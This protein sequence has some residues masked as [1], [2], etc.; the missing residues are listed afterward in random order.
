M[1]NYLIASVTIG[2]LLTACRKEDKWPD[3]PITIPIAME[4]VQKDYPFAEKFHYSKLIPLETTEQCRIGEIQRVFSVDSSFIVWDGKKV[5]VF[6]SDGLYISSIGHQGRAS[7]EYMRISDVNVDYN[8]KDIYLLDNLSR[9]ILVYGIRGDFKKRISIENYATGF[10]STHNQLWLEN[11]ALDG[12]GKM[13]LCTDINTNEIQHGYFPFIEG[14]KI[15]IPDE[16]SFFWGDS[17]ALFASPYM[18]T[19]YK[20]AGDEIAPY[21]KINFLDNK[22]D[23]RDDMTMPEFFQKIAEEGYIGG[24]K[25]VYQVNSYLFFSFNRNN[26]GNSIS[27]FNVCY[28]MDSQDADI[29]DFSLLHDSRMPV[30]PSSNIKGVY[31]DGVIFCLDISALPDFLLKKLKE[32]TGLEDLDNSSNP[33]LILYDVD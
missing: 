4:Q 6:D 18:N 26:T 10:L 13:L 33:I 7:N 5:A 1:K 11:Y 22:A 3:A 30:F 15:P 31:R 8:T 12:P 19:I 14:E 9:K 17:I 25:D 28:N 21:V 24:I 23:E 20:I 27:E 2:I 29:Y 32:S 16:K